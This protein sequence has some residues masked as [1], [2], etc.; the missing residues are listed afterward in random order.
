MCP[1]DTGQADTASRQ[2]PFPDPLPATSP[3]ALRHPI[4]PLCW[5]QMSR[6][7]WTQF[8]APLVPALPPKVWAAL[9]QEHQEILD[10]LLPWLRQELA[11]MFGTVW[12]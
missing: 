4:H 3:T 7:L 6:G 11:V 1:E 10:P 5:C 9:F 2:A 12:W 8:S